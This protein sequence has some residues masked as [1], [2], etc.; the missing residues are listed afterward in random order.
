MKR[1]GI[2]AR[3]IN[4]T[5]VGVYTRNLLKNLEQHIFQFEVYVYLRPIDYASI[6]FTN[7]LFIKRKA[8]YHWHSFSEQYSFFKQL[9]K[10]NL[11][12]MH[13]TY[14]SYPILY[15]RPF[16]ITIHDL[17]PLTH[18]T[19]RASTLGPLKYNLKK[20]GYRLALSSGVKNAR[21]IITPSQFVKN[22]ITEHFGNKYGEKINITYEGI[23]EELLGADENVDLSKKFQ[24]PFFIYVGNFYPHKNV[25][26]LMKAFSQLDIKY[27]LILI[28]PDDYFA[29]RAHQLLSHLQTKNIIFCHNPSLEDFVYF[30]KNAT[31]L[32]HPSLTEGFG[33]PLIEKSFYFSR[34]KYLLKG[35]LL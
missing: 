29:K 30:Y 28:G 25:E 16:V 32:I 4:Q 33:L 20:I 13:F 18:T 8:D 26:K 19:G 14:F 22:S 7:K 2:D 23:N 3:L 11:D 27:S 9:T 6:D 21:R 24:K 35:N 34:L 5:G 12:L 31:A 15:R 17:I 10:D 1:I